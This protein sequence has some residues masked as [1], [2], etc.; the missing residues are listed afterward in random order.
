MKV[1]ARTCNRVF[2]QHRL[3]E[4]DALEWGAAGGGTQHAGGADAVADHIHGAALFAGQ[5]GRNGGD[6]GIFA[7]QL[8]RVR[9][10]HWSHGHAGPWPSRAGARP[11][12]P[13]HAA[14]C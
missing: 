14:S 11:A 6:I 13:T 4:H 9:R 1:Q 8:I 3:V 5:C 12:P 2:D 10:R 7:A